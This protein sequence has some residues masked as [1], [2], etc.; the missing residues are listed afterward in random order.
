MKKKAKKVRKHRESSGSIG[1]NIGKDKKKE[2][3]QVL[4]VRTTKCY[5]EGEFLCANCIFN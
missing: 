4:R 3:Q 1:K 5:C 2:V